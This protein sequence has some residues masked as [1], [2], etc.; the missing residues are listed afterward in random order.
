MST[1]TEPSIAADLFGGMRPIS[2]YEAAKITGCHY[3]VV[4]RWALHGVTRP[5]S[6]PLL[7]KARRIGRTL[8]TTRKW[9][10]E[11]CEERASA[12][13]HSSESQQP[14]KRERTARNT[15]EHGNAV[16]Q[17]EGMGISCGTAAE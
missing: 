3:K 7:L 17:L 11:F 15:R 12:S 13:P 6:T 4:S 16:E 5:P 9:L 2:M 10:R 14:T 1:A 8:F